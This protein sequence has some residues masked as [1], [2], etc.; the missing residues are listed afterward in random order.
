M[1]S[2]EQDLERVKAVWGEQAGTWYVG[3]GVHWVE[4][5]K[6]QERINNKVTGG[7]AVDRFHYFVVKYF[8]GRT[9]VDRALTLGC[10]AGEFE[11]GLA[12]YGFC[13][14]HEAIDVADGAIARA[15]DLARAAGFTHIRYR[16]DDLNTIELEP[17]HYDVIFGISAVHHVAMLERLYEQ[18][19][20]ALK[21]G[22]YFF[23]D[24][25]VGPSQFQWTD[26]QLAVV[27]EQLRIMPPYLKRSVVNGAE[28]RGLAV[29]PEVAWMNESDPSEAIRSA[30]IV[31]LLPG[32]FEVLEQ[33]GWGGSLLHLLLEDIAGNFDERNEGSLAY[34]EEL[35]ELEDR[36][37][38]DGVLQDDFATIIARRR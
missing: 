19:A 34:L 13:R 21:P 18:V 20:R 32:Y 23:L 27:N 30:E 24:E 33:K 25:Y 1:G 2:R 16:I 4:H 3:R 6:V 31:P 35:F 38:A 37:I 22:G 5:K 7:S 8:H 36:L 10:G 11:R 17:E 29:R 9:P 14:R 26:T 15:V 12:Q 28:S